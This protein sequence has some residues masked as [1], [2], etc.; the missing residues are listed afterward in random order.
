M[1]V[2]RE[3]LNYRWYYSYLLSRTSTI[4]LRT[5]KSDRLS[6]LCNGNI[7]KLLGRLLA[8]AFCHSLST[9]YS[10]YRSRNKRDAKSRERARNKSSL[11]YGGVGHVHWET[12]QPPDT[13]CL[14]CRPYIPPFALPLRF[15]N[16]AGWFYSPLSLILT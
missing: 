5:A 13:A 10:V 3:D 9:P 11:G 12:L 16:A 1:Y 7:Y 14:P 6:G 8:S 15:P 4:C 2:F